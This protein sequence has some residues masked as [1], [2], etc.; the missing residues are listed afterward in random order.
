M[1]EPFLKWAGGKR[2]LVRAG[3]LSVP[4]HYNRFI[5]P[6]LGGGAVFFA[7][8]PSAAILSDVNSEL[9]ELY[10]IVRDEPVAL[11]DVLEWHQSRHSR[12]HYYAIRGRQ[13]EGKVWRAARTLYLNRT[14]WNGLYRLNRKGEFNVPMGS[15]TD[16]LIEDDFLSYSNALSSAFLLCS[17]FEQTIDMAKDGDFIFADPP[18]TVKHNMNGFVKYNEKIFSW[19]DQIRLREACTRAANRGA[20]V[21]IANADHPS[22]HD[23][24]RGLGRTEKLARHSVISGRSAGRGSVT[25]ALILMDPR[26]EEAGVPG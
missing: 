23:L 8:E 2:W 5:E 16:I 6:F 22:I 19:E 13:F 17:D 10:E 14:C 20:T 18:Y 21:V 1:G 15:K 4:S 12:E 7:L 9:V 24:Y 26:R 11:R 25:E 3:S